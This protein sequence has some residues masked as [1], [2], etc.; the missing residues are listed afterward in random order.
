MKKPDSCFACS[1]SA[2]MAIRARSSPEKQLKLSTSGRCAKAFTVA[3][4]AA[5][6]RGEGATIAIRSIRL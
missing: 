3:E 5:P 6:G 4:K 1:M 2:V